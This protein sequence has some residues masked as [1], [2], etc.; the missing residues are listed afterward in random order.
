[1]RFR[2]C[3]GVRTQCKPDRSRRELSN[4]SLVAKDGFDTAKTASAPISVFALTFQASSHIVLLVVLVSVTLCGK[5]GFFSPHARA[6]DSV[7]FRLF[8]PLL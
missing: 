4:E 2:R 1:M 7:V 8:V 3:E 5:S 6:S